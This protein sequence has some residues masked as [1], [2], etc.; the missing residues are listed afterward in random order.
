M[1]L[2]SQFLYL[3][4]YFNS[5]YIFIKNFGKEK[6]IRKTSICDVYIIIIHII[7]I[8]QSDYTSLFYII[9][10]YYYFKKVYLLKLFFK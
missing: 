4:V 1:N 2:K 9:N 8:K 10:Y 7:N 3:F 6:E 5:Y